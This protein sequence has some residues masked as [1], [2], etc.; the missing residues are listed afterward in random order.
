[1]RHFNKIP[2]DS[3]LPP[4]ARASQTLV[5]LYAFRQLWLNG[6]ETDSGAI[7]S[8]FGPSW[9]TSGN[10]RDRT[11]K[12]LNAWHNLTFLANETIILGCACKVYTCRARDLCEPDGLVF[13]Q[14]A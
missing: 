13:V 7:C 2:E 12:Q 4:D 3:K 10:D 1:M 14:L 8:F 6:V 5:N 9:D 11:A